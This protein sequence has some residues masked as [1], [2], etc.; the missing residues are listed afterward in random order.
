MGIIYFFKNII[1]PKNWPL[2][3]FILL[4]LAMIVFLCVLF[5]IGF[6]FNNFKWD[7]DTFVIGLIGIGVYLFLLFL[8]LTPVGEIF[9]RFT[10]KLKV[11]E[12]TEKT[13][14]LYAIF[15]E[16]YEKALKDYKGLSKK[17]KL[18]LYDSDDPNAFA[19]GRTTLAISYALLDLED[20]EIKGI[21]AHEFY[22]LAS[23]DSLMKSALIASNGVL[24]VVV[25]LI[26]LVFLF[27][28]WLISVIFYTLAKIHP[29]DRHY[30]L[31]SLFSF[32]VSILYTLWVLFGSLL[33]L[34]TS[35]SAEFKADGGAK[36]LGYGQ[37]L[38]NALQKLDP[39]LNFKASLAEIVTSTHP[40]T[41]KRIEKLLA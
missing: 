10:N 2:L 18:C 30:P 3:L 40:A 4:N 39:H 24:L 23:C 8:M 25:A 14:G 34:K 21:L 1:K 35:R 31:C 20:D 26:K 28:I 12:R 41:A 7:L 38:A 11:L 29:D 16:V 6:D 17:V 19:L 22:H 37:D 32:L 15:D 36:Q 9:L 5:S 33:M 27:V 13:A